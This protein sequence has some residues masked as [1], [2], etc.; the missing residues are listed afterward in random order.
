MSKR[1]VVEL[2]LLAGAL[3]VVAGI[4]ADRL[5]LALGL[6]AIWCVVAALADHRFHPRPAGRRYLTDLA[7]RLERGATIRS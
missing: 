7:V 4:V 3:M 2:A 1:Q 6:T 5:S